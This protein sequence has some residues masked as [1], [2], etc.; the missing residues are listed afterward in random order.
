MSEPTLSPAFRGISE[1]MLGVRPN[2]AM[3]VAQHPDSTDEVNHGN[4]E[5]K[6]HRKRIAEAHP[7]HLVVVIER[8]G[9]DGPELDFAVRVYEDL[10]DDLDG[11]TPVGTLEAL[12]ARFGRAFRV[13]ETEATFLR[14]E[15]V[16]VGRRKDLEVVGANRPG[17][18]PGVFLGYGAFQAHP[19]PVMSC[20]L[21]WNLDLFQYGI[22]R[23][24]N[25]KKS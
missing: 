18:T 2:H 13:G 14:E 5:L 6:V 1:R 3:D 7:P 19:E 21:L 20:T 22:W 10:A 23:A 25:R 11:M 16:K 12:A 4:L 15:S 9:R 24:K 8:M 17:A